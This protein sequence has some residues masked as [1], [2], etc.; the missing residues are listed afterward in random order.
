[1][2]ALV[3]HVLHGR[4][5]RGTAEV[6]LIGSWWIVSRRRKAALLLLLLISPMV[7]VTE[8]AEGVHDIW[9][10]IRQRA[11]LR[12]YRRY[13]A[14]GIRAPLRYEGSSFIMFCLPLDQ[15]E[16]EILPFK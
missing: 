8:M 9:I 6:G 4:W 16:L 7:V 11:S 14:L 2:S 10:R 3:R 15:N 12:S 5:I 13:I 1:M